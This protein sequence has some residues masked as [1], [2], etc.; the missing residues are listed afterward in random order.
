MTTGWPQ[1]ATEVCQDFPAAP[2]PS[3]TLISWSVLG[4]SLVLVSLTRERVVHFGV[5]CRVQPIMT[6]SVTWD[7]FWLN[8][9]E[10]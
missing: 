9:A 3:R 1:I 8:P 7:Q 6:S 2:W 5:G 10:N 4:P